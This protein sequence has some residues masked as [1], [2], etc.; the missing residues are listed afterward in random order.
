MK[1]KHVNVEN[2]RNFDSE[3]MLYILLGDIKDDPGTEIRQTLN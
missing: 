1:N 3:A 2:K